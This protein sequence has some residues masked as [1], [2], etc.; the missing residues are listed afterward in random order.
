MG[1]WDMEEK[2]YPMSIPSALALAHV[3]RLGV[4]RGLEKRECNG[5]YL[6][7]SI[8]HTWLSEPGTT[9]LL[10]WKRENP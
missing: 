9:Y 6:H 2:V 8:V 10:M 7:T 4:S 1:H 3:C 5:S